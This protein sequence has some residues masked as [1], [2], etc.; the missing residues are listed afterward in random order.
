MSPVVRVI[1]ISVSETSRTFTLENAPRKCHMGAVGGHSGESQSQVRPMAVAVA[2]LG[3]LSLV[4]NKR[5]HGPRGQ[6]LR[7][8]YPV[9]A[10]AAS[11]VARVANGPSQYP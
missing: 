9:L 4:L 10:W 6:R 11:A 7:R 8:A 2:S 5:A 1:I 3:S